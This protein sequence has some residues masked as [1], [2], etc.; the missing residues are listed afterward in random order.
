MSNPI[1]VFPANVAV[2]LD[3][4]DQ[5]MPL[6]LR[7]PDAVITAGPDAWEACFWAI[8]LADTKVLDDW[9]WHIEVNSY[10]ELELTMFPGLPYDLYHG[11]LAFTLYKW[12]KEHDYPGLLS[13]SKRTAYRLSNGAV[14]RPVISWTLRDNVIVPESPFFT[15]YR[16]C[17]DFAAEIRSD[18]HMLPVLLNKMREYMDNGTRL[19]WLID[20][21]ER[22]VR[23]YRTGADEP[24]LL[25]DPETLNGE[26][27][28]PGFVFEV[29]QQI[30]DL[31]PPF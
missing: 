6:V 24:E 23:I 31:S 3:A 17:P 9:I 14:R 25:H 15:S 30:F 12:N 18:I 27:V 5:L 4:Y 2:I 7:F 29:R 13:S 16:N 26:Y 20:P 8:R 1:T 19:G 11:E 22:T 21:L 28:L 10:G